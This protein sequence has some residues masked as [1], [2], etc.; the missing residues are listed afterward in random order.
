M[1]F[2]VVV[3]VLFLE[4]AVACKTSSL[5]YGHPL[6]DSVRMRIGK[7]SKVSYHSADDDF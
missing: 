5:V 7:F 4:L 3:V 6:F 2:F 1:W